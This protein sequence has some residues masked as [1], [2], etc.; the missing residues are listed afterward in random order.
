MAD[1]CFKEDSFHGKKVIQVAVKEP[2]YVVSTD[3]AFAQVDA[4][5]WAYGAGS[6]AG[7]YLSGAHGKTSMYR[8]DLR[9]CVAADECERTSGIPL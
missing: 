1:R 2:Q 9:R 3:V 8:V 7:C 4:M 5:V 6:E